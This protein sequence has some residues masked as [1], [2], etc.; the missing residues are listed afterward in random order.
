MGFAVLNPSYGMSNVP[1][2][3]AERS[4]THR[5]PG[6]RSGHVSRISPVPHTATRIDSGN[7]SRQ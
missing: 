1:V 6:Y 3:W 4:E 2:G 5:R 7:P